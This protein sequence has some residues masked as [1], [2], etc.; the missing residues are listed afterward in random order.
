MYEAAIPLV[1]LGWIDS[2][3]PGSLAKQS[4]TYLCTLELVVEN[5]GD[6]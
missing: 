4:I 2:G 5:A 6:D 1:P 3:F